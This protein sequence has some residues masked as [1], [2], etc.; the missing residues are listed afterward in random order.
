ML[1]EEIMWIII[2]S[3]KMQSGLV[4]QLCSK[5]AEVRARAFQFLKCNGIS[6]TILFRRVQCFQH[7]L[8]TSGPL[9]DPESAKCNTFSYGKVCDFITVRH[10]HCKIEDPILATI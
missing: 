5:S 3:L 8:S 10:W 6:G 7:F 1:A 4:F 2:S 9:M